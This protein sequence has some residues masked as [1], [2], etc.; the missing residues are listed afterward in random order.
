[1]VAGPVRINSP[2]AE[3]SWKELLIRPYVSQLARLDGLHGLQLLHRFNTILLHTTN[4][5]LVP[6]YFQEAEI[7]ILAGRANRHSGTG[8]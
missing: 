2:S 7:V 6:H 5:V 1:M 3:Q 8:G 4:L